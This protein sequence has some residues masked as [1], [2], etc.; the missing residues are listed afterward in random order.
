LVSERRLIAAC[1]CL[2]LWGSAVALRLF[3]LHVLEA[4]YYRE[5]AARQQLFEAG[6][7]PLRGAIRDRRGNELAISIE[8][9]S[10][11]AQP[12]R[13]D[14]PFRTAERLAGI[15]GQT[16][17]SLRGKLTSDEPF[18]WLERK[19][20]AAESAAIREAGLPG[21]GLQTESRRY[22]PNLQLTAHVL[23][24]VNLDNHGVGGLEYEYDELIS[25][26]AGKLVVR[27]DAHNVTFEQLE[28]S[29]TAGASL[30]TTLDT[31][32]QHFVEAEIS[33]TV[34]ETRAIG[35]SVIVMDPDS[36]GILAMGNYPTYNPNDYA[37]SPEINWSNR[38][39]KHLYEPGS[40][41]KIATAAAVLEEGLGRID[42]VV[43]GR[44]GSIVVHNVRIRDHKPFGLLTMREVLQYSSNVGMIQ[45][46]SR[47]GAGRFAEYI[48]RFGFG[49]RTG[50]DL[51][52]EEAGLVR[53]VAQW[54]GLS[55][56]VIS[57]GQE[58]S[59]TPMQVLNLAAAVGNGGTI[60]RP[61]VVSRIEHVDGRVEV[62]EPE[63]RRVMETRTARLVGDALTRVV[64]DGT[65]QS[66]SIPGFTS[67][68]KTGTAQKFDPATGRYSDT[69]YVAS[70]AGYAPAR[71]PEVA[72]VVVIDEPRGAYHGG[73]VAAPVFGRLASEILRYLDVSPDAP[74]PAPEFAGED[75]SLP[76]TD[77]AEAGEDAWRVVDASLD[78]APAAQGG[79][80]PGARLRVPD[81]RGRPLRGVFGDTV[82]LGLGL[83]SSGSGVGVEQWPPP[84]ALVEP[85]ATVEVRFAPAGR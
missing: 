43:D 34:R 44:N 59:A 1:V 49:Q 48:E 58:L 15:L 4:A 45:F 2:A 79:E 84:G 24:F 38:A 8:V 20:T 39:I 66:A 53:P 82:R 30:D 32:I 41:F 85:G 74:L 40:T 5:R 21:V 57:I 19:I 72:I 33:R 18:V 26:L 9:D 81:F 80:A 17:A 51:M 25:G 12:R 67:A 70:F 16:A 55:T 68:G 23:G 62:T 64:T 35:M 65:G 61:F 46:G 60:H 37:R 69:R 13:V 77:D 54:S 42:E 10:A 27:R 56:S 7:S 36:G 52:G 11:Y 50:I 63:G 71:R 22:Y 73:E 28:R 3:D 78:P 29:P 75:E 31:S 14:D 76:V 83:V 6:I 47:L